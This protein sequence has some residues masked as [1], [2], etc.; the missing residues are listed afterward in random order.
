MEG[1]IDWRT[2]NMTMVMS[3]SCG[4]PLGGRFPCALLDAL[5]ILGRNRATHSYP[6]LSALTFQ[7]AAGPPFTRR[8]SV[9]H[10]CNTLFPAI[11]LQF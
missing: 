5:C 4:P 7:K 11:L 1:L 6:A 2:S 3:N 8:Y 10:F 9:L